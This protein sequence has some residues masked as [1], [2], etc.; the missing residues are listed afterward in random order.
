MD[1]DD[2][3]FDND[4]LDWSWAALWVIGLSSNLGENHIRDGR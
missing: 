1:I 3:Q 4:K 2:L